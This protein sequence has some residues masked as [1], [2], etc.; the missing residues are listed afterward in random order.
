MFKNKFCTKSVFLNFI[1]HFFHF[2]VLG[3]K[4][5]FLIK[6]LICGIWYMYYVLPTQIFL[7]FYAR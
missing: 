4:Q 2:R 1:L 5:L 6:I 3:T 7:L